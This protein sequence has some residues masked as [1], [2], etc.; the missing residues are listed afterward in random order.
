MSIFGRKSTEEAY[1]DYLNEDGSM[2]GKKDFEEFKQIK[3]RAQ[4]ISDGT[5]SGLFE[6]DEDVREEV[7]NI[8]EKE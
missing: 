5:T 6:K 8:K 2:F 1:E 7:N 4:E 3:E